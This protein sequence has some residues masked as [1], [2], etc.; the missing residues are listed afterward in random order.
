M[1][2]AR[3]LVLNLVSTESVY[4]L[5]PMENGTEIE[6]KDEKIKRGDSELGATGP[7]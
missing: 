1:T 4:D 6:Q 2:T 5:S 7:G 3:I